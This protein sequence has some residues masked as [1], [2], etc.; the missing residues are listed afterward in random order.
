META[1]CQ[2]EK[3]KRNQTTTQSKPIQVQLENKATY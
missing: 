2:E 1:S 3:K